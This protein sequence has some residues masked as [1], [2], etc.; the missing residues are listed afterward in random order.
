MEDPKVTC[1]RI[2]NDVDLLLG[3]Y[4]T[5][6]KAYPYSNLHGERVNND[7]EQRRNNISYNC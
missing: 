6:E 3:L 7:N 1:A 2:E 4:S 5:A